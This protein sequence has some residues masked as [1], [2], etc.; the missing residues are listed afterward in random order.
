M[1]EVSRNSQILIALT[2]ANMGEPIKIIDLAKKMR[3]ENI[4]TKIVFLT[5]YREEDMFNK[6]LDLGADGYVLKDNAVIDIVNC[7][8]EVSDDNYYISPA[9]SHLLLNRQR[10][11][12]KLNSQNP[13]LESLTKSEKK[14]LRIIAE[15]KTS[16]E[17][18]EELYVSVKTVENHRTNIS[19]KL[20]LHGSHSL[21][22]YAFQNKSIL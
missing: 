13:K 18:A 11:K 20:G 22:K 8:K 21:V 4:D 1:F 15:D 3:S 5:M 9:V 6:A 14:I 12:G 16:R 10:Q 17:I 2:Y 19:R 7:I